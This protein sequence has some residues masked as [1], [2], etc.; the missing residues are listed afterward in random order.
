[1][2][3]SSESIVQGLLTPTNSENRTPLMCACIEGNAAMVNSM[4]DEHLSPEKQVMARDIYGNTPLMLA[5]SCRQ[6]TCIAVLV[7]HEPVKQLFCTV[8]G[9]TVLQH[10]WRAREEI[11]FQTIKFIVTILSSVRDSKGVTLIM[12]LCMLDQPNVLEAL[13]GIVSEKA[14]QAILTTRDDQGRTPLMYAAIANA[15]KNIHLLLSKYLHGP[16]HVNAV[17]AQGCNALRLAQLAGA[18]DAVNALLS[19]G[20]ST[21]GPEP[22]SNVN[23]NNKGEGEGEMVE[24]MTYLTDEFRNAFI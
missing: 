6:Y 24:D 5:L 12:V 14:H 2:M 4:L 16:E 17:D 1:M 23:I 13:S 8:K 19:H 15:A 3:S 20:S 9:E 18:S 22:Q 7:L 11:P 10:I 21:V